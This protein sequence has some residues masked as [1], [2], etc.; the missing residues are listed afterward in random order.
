MATYEQLSKELIINVLGKEFFIVKKYS[1]EK[2]KK[3]A[4]C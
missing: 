2:N 1:S 4:V 3:E